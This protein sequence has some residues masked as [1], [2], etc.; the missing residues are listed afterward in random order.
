MAGFG[1]SRL[2]GLARVPPRGV[3]RLAA[4]LATALVVPLVLV[5]VW[6]DASLVVV[7]ALAMTSAV[8]AAPAVG[9]RTAIV[10]AGAAA[11]LA[12][13]G[14]L[15]G[16]S[17]AWL[18]LLIAVGCVIHGV[19]GR[20]HAGGLLLLPLIVDVIAGIGLDAS[21]VVV[22]AAV[23]VAGCYGIVVTRVLRV[24]MP[25]QPL[26]VR[27]VQIHTV[28]VTLAVVAT[29]I[30]V[31]L[32][33][34]PRA[35]WIPLTVLVV[36]RPFPVETRRRLRDRTV[37]TA[38]GGALAAVVVLVLPQ[39]LL[40]VLATSLVVLVIAYGATGDYFRSVIVL[41]PMVVILGGLGDVQAQIEASVLRVGLT[42]IGAAAAAA[43]AYLMREAQG[44]TQDA[45]KGTR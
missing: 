2:A 24:R 29:S 1:A 35:Y 32:D 39:A 41:T 9:V 13:G 31:V 17:P 42:L 12:G 30:P 21:A 33:A 18:L 26:D 14:A 3:L 7:A 36:L 20:V 44:N 10:F 43:A 37:G 40:L 22:A 38:L 8:T 27:T 11:V 15:A 28:V 45:S 23:F 25:A 5:A 34:L 6:A 19:A 4:I 16:D